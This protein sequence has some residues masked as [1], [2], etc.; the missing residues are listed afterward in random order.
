[1]AF[2]LFR[3][4]ELAAWLT[5]TADAYQRNG[6]AGST[7]VMVGQ[8]VPA[9]IFAFGVGGLIRRW[10]PPRVLRSGLAAQAVGMA[11][12]AVGLSGIG[13]RPVG[14]LGVVVTAIAVTTIRP[15]V[16]VLSPSIVTSPDQLTATNLVLG[17]L[18]GAAALAGPALAA[19]LMTTLGAGSV[20]AVLAVGLTVATLLVVAIPA[21]TG[22]G[23]TV[24]DATSALEGVRQVSR[25]RGPRLLLTGLAVHSLLMGALDL[26]VVVI[27]VELLD[28]PE[29]FG[30]YLGSAIGL[31]GIA[32]ALAGVAVIGRRQLAS[33]ITTSALVAAAALAAVS[34]LGDTVAPT[35]LCMVLC[36]A[37][38]TLYDLM[39]RMLLQRVTRLDLLGHAF[40]ALECLQLAMLAIGVLTVPV[41]VALFGSDG[42]PAAIGALLAV[43]ALLSAPGIASVDRGAQVPITEMAL[44]RSTRLFGPLPGPALESLA[45]EARRFEVTAGTIVLTE[46]E[47]GDD[48]FA[49]IEGDFHITV[50]GQ[51]VNTVI[52][53]DGFGEIALLRQVA[54]TGTVIAATDGVLLA[55]DRDTFLVTLTGH[56]PTMGQ[57][58]QIA[59]E[60]S[61]P[62]PE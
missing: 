60:W 61:A 41:A 56:A 13:P 9:A 23:A 33:W 51:R 46:G 15:S 21:G 19:V 16:S 48:Y 45:R 59:I 14:Y 18:D 17:W 26:L 27:A 5:L 32:A 28:R 49:V 31:G 25:T 11:V 43:T 10:G 44:L 35:L 12:A 1:M 52:R 58:Q 57:A 7:A 53:G 29:E 2:G 55:I 22:G 40:A 3:T 62:D 8:L 36:G 47:R 38:A 30:G 6:I 37:G 34:L 20:F 54:R 39:S 50:R 42:A 24:D 4:A